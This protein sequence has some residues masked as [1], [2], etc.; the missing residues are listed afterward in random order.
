[1]LHLA[2]CIALLLIFPPRQDEAREMRLRLGKSSRR[3]V[4]AGIMLVAFL[5]RGLIPQGFMPASGQPLSLEICWEGL[6]AEMLAHSEPSRSE[7]M[8]MDME[9]MS[10]DSMPADSM[11]PI[12]LS[13][14]LPLQAGHHS[15]GTPQGEHCV[16]G[17][18]CCAGPTPHLPRAGDFASTITRHAVAFASMAVD[19]RVVHLPQSR[20]PPGQLS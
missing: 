13:R 3:T 10:M 17:T 12:S 7:P 16:F 14:N 11:A 19:V 5:S 15:K 9:S 6:P 8:D 2:R 18:A 20:A 4:I 1:M